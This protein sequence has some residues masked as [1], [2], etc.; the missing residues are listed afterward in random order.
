VILAC[1]A[2]A[3]GRAERLAAGEVIRPELAT[4]A[5]PT[6]ALDQGWRDPPSASRTR[7]WWWWLNGNV[8]KDS[9][10]SDL[11]AM[12]AKG[13]GGAN[14]IDA[15]GADERNNRQVPHGPDFGS[16]AWRELFLHALR[17]A[18]RL[19]LEL[20]FMIQSGWNLGGPTVAPA[21]A[22]KKLAYSETDVDGGRLVE[23]RL[24]RP[25][26]IGNFYVDVATVAFPLPAERDVDPAR[27]N[28]FAAKAYYE[29]PGGFVA[30]DAAHLLDVAPVG[31]DERPVAAGS[32]IDLTGSLDAQGRL[33]W[34]APAGQWRVLRIGYT[35]AG[36][37][38]STHSE[39]WDGWAIDYLDPQAFDRY[40]G[41]VVEPLLDAAGPLVGRSLRFLHTDSWELGP[42]NWTPRLPEKFRQRH[43]YE[44]SRYWPVLAGYVVD[45]AETSTRF[46]ND[47]RRTLAELIAAGNYGP[48]AAHAHA[49]GLGI[50]PESGGPHAAPVDALMTLGR[51]DI[52]MGEFWARSPTHRVHDF[53]RFFIKQPA[54]AAHIYGR[55]LVLAE[56]FTSIGPQWEEDPQSLKP[57]FDRV[58]CE[59]LNLVML[60]TF[61][62]SPENMGVPGQAYFAGT[63]INLRVTWWRH[64]EAFFGYL[65]RCQFLL[66]QGLPV[67]DVLYFYGENVPSFVRLKRDDPA[68]TLPGYDYDVTSAEAL[69]ERTRVENG[70]IVLPDGVSYAVLALPPGDCYGLAALEHIAKLVDAGARVVGEKPR[71]PI[72]LSATPAD[73]QKFAELAE[74]LWAAGRAGGAPAIA[75]VPVR[76]AL[77]AAGIEADFAYHAATPGGELDYFHRRSTAGD[78]YFVANRSAGWTAAD[79]SFRLS[80]MQPELWDPVTGRT[81]D[82]AAFQQAGG[83]TL[84]PLKLPPG[85]S[86]FVVFRRPIAPSARGAASTNAPALARRATVA[87]PWQVSFDPKWGGPDAPLTFHALD[88][89]SQRPEE[90]VKYFSGTAV[91]RTT[92]ELP[93]DFAAEAGAARGTPGGGAYFLDLGRV[94]NVAAVTL[95]GAPLGVAWTEPFRVDATAALRPGRN[96]LLVEVTNLWPNRLIGDRRLPHDERL[97][98]TNITKFQANSRL[99]PSGLLG[100]VELLEARDDGPEAADQAAK[101]VHRPKKVSGTF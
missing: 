95:N 86:A 61:D 60:H 93:A 68:K 4:S 1:L 28:N 43:G 42:V 87:G 46:L 53:E 83:R 21:D 7:C 32:V 38:V 94:E 27:V 16:P 90:G 50:H 62:S 8:T 55:R 49:R 17:E 57:E 25:R 71:R 31:D 19:G 44:L 24:R 3:A 74:R 84:V 18:D 40:W 52:P 56:S 58:A 75:N 72:G 101:R 12:A 85:G 77:V 69:I 67:A 76:D 14:I 97:T 79:A 64:A 6:V 70:R 22:A 2:G 11:E 29:Y 13:L 20:G 30:I 10:T 96:T 88:D 36:S 35:L 51:S 41:D 99:L 91:Y 98:S 59:G 66:Q 5:A 47:F 34:Q 81:A 23:R 26:T 45:D 89:W 48:F 80:G 65:N 33:R 92:F 54:S 82:A 63:H 100:P 39:G 78:I 15:G 37:R 73:E 9:I